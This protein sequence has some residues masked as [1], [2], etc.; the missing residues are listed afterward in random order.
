MTH[1]WRNSR[2]RNS[3]R[4]HLDNSIGP[5]RRRKCGRRT[6][7]SHIDNL[8]NSRYHCR[9][10]P[11]TT[12]SPWGRSSCP[13]LHHKYSR[14]T[15]RS[16]MSTSRD[17]HWIRKYD[18]R[19]IR[20]RSGMTKMTRFHCRYDHRNSCNPA[21]SCR[22]IR[23]T[24]KLRRHNTHSQ[25]SRCPFRP[26]RIYRFRTR[27]SPWGRRRVRPLH[28]RRL[29]KAPSG[30]PADRWLYFPTNHSIRWDTCLSCN[31]QD[32]IAHFR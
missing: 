10:G 4:N 28:I 13:R 25:R 14:R 27:C 24:S 32:T 12:R 18:R 20:N 23:G 11:R 16:H 30:S 2:P 29:R 31:L 22:S 17:S 15:R 7:R 8:Y 9:F 6:T 1:R 26:F 5:R 21:D 3:S 19:N